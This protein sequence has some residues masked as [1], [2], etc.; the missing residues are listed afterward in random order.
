MAH[1]NYLWR[2]LSFDASLPH[3]QKDFK[4]CSWP[5]DVLGAELLSLEG[6]C[7]WDK[8][9]WAPGRKQSIRKKPGSP[10]PALFASSPFFPDF[11]KCPRCSMAAQ[12][13]CLPHHLQAGSW[14]SHIPSSEFFYPVQKPAV[15]EAKKKIYCNYF[16]P[17]NQPWLKILAHRFNQNRSKMSSGGFVTFSGF[18]QANKTL[19]TKGIQH[20]AQSSL[21]RD[22]YQRRKHF[23]L[24]F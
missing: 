6:L 13:S 3:G 2:N 15:I 16:S 19:L 17:Q 20:K 11:L 21:Y 4:F 23:W 12:N 7:R 5:E 22:D 24:C 1:P 10:I 18:L 9:L 14:W 8:H